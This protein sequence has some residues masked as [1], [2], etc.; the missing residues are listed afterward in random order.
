MILCIFSDYSQICHCGAINCK[1]FI[2]KND[3]KSSEEEHHV[4][5]PVDTSSSKTD[6]EQSE[7]QQLSEH[8]HEDDVEQHEKARASSSDKVERSRKRGRPLKKN[9]HKRTV[10]SL[11][12]MKGRRSRDN[13]RILKLR[14][15]KV[16]QPTN[17]EDFVSN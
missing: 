16:D 10:K 17:E 2:G 15:G 4:D 14:L 3:Q 1:G 8:E 12:N 6:S 13:L 11:E 9:A 7:D 5:Q